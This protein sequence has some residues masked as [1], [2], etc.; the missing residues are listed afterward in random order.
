MQSNKRALA[1][2]RFESYRTLFHKR[3]QVETFNELLA[4]FLPVILNYFFHHISKNEVDGKALRP[5]HVLRPLFGY[6]MACCQNTSQNT[7]QNTAIYFSKY[8]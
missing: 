4:L 2:K 3:F 1:K 5:P 7:S 6:A 8:C